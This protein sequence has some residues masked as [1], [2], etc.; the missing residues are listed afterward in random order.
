MRPGG[1]V[2]TLLLAGCLGIGLAAPG[3]AA[4]RPADPP[5]TGFLTVDITDVGGAVISVVQG[6]TDID[7]TPTPMGL[8]L[9]PG[10]YQLYATAQQSASGWYAGADG[11][12]RSGS[13]A[14]QV[15]ATS[16]TLTAGE[17]KTI[18][19]DL[20]APAELRGRVVTSSGKPVS[21]L[22]VNTVDASNG[23]E[24]L[25]HAIT[26]ADGSWTITTALPGSY[27]VQVSCPGNTYP[28]APWGYPTTYYDGKTGSLVASRA[29][30]LAITT[31]KDGVANVTVSAY[32]EL[33]GAAKLPSGAVVHLDSFAPGSATPKDSV[34]VTT[35]SFAF[36][37]VLPGKY[38]VAFYCQGGATCGDGVYAW[39]GGDGIQSSTKTVTVLPGKAL[40]V[41]EGAIP[42]VAADVTGYLRQ[43]KAEK[44]GVTCEFVRGSSCKGSLALTT[45][46]PPAHPHKKPTH[47]TSTARFSV[48]E[49]AGKAL[50]FTLIAAARKRLAHHHGVA[51]TFTLRV[52]G[53]A[54]RTIHFTIH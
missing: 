39:Y 30:P 53:Q 50:S 12:G 18:D 46:L 49:H 51:A 54:T 23:N 20:A 22:C 34:A 15:D 8:E 5:T 36:P 14:T 21:G 35:Q 38:Q 24:A 25:Y 19:W 45:T 52:T 44:A 37:Y 42:T 3:A 4:G 27:N 41:N 29:K 11:P 47:H 31:T 33:T 9:P 13:V 28:G 2:A 10:T 26:A 32:G 16:V 17:D 1:T 40:R 7:A 6:A 48:T 43:G